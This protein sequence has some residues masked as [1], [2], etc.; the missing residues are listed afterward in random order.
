MDAWR[1]RFH[2]RLDRLRRYRHIMA[3]LMKY[4]LEEIAA[5]LHARF[6]VRFGQKEMPPDVR[7]A[8][9]GRSRPERVRLAL[10]EL[11]PT[12]I[13][14]GQL[15]STRP[16]IVSAEYVQELE[17]LQDRVKPEDREKI[18]AEIEKQLGG[19]AEQIFSRFD[20]EPLA[21]GSIAQVHYAVTRQGRPV[22][23]K[24]RRPGIVELV[25]AECAILQELA[26]I[27]KAMLFEHET[28]DP[29]EMVSELTDAIVRET[30][31]VN[32]RRNQ[33]RFLHSFADDPAVHVPEVYMDY[34]SEGVLT[35]EYIDGVKPGD[36][37]E[38]AEKGFDCKLIGK[39]A[40]DFLFEQ[41]FE[42]GFFHTDPHPGNFFVLPGNVLAPIDFGQVTTLSS[43]DRRLFD[44]IV[45]AVVDNE[46]KR[47]VDAFEREDMIEPRQTDVARLTLDVEQIVGMYWNLP[48]K[49]IPFR[50]VVL[51]VFDVFRSHHV[52]PPSGFVLT[53]KSLMTIE[54]FARS[55]DPEFN[56]I[57]ALR[58]Y[59]RRSAFRAVEP[60][61]VLH[62]MRQIFEDA[63]DLAARIPKDLNTIITRIRQG[64]FEL[65]V[66]H[67]HLEALT[68]T[69]DKSSNRIS[70]ALIIAALLIASSLLVAQEGTVLGLF[71]LQ[72]MGI[73]G[74]VMAA[75]IGIT[76]LISILRSGKL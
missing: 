67:E 42:L 13:K 37:R 40:A 56:I 21:A 35:M 45:L 72:S 60:R 30:D 48:L 59:A 38:L 75:I 24:V 32:E 71:R 70:F 29:Q 73:F 55:M 26:G 17:R 16:D 7:R 58:P 12:F 22:A 28:I 6:L 46:G 36:R 41:I 11:G 62:Q 63:G 39:R 34:C 27:L 1:R 4:G 15:L 18:R 66:H 76:L 64:K 23:V 20:P 43:R 53:L 9:E 54:S 61:H 3:V 51:K 49:E 8:A 68:R 31:L 52:R 5:T 74:Y 10:E 19:K 57:E 65:R 69:L 44:Q 25:E 33:L 50:T 2:G 14:F 47:I